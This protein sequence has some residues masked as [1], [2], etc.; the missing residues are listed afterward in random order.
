VRRITSAISELSRSIMPRRI[1]DI[2]FD[3]FIEHG[4]IFGHNSNPF[5]TLEGITVH[6]QITNYLVIPEHLA[7]LEH[8]VYQGSFPMVYMG[9]NSDIS[10]VM[11]IIHSLVQVT[12]T[13]TRPFRTVRRPDWRGER[14]FSLSGAGLV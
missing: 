8:S 1:D 5:F 14:K 10:Y 6:Y 2:D 11:A 12:A 7:L 13:F 4:C 3:P 9:D